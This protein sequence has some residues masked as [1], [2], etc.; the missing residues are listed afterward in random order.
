MARHLLWAALSFDRS[1][2]I[3]PTGDVTFA[4]RIDHI[5]HPIP[6]KAPK[7]FSH[8]ILDILEVGLVIQ[9]TTSFNEHLLM[10]DNVI[11]IFKID[12]AVL[13]GLGAYKNN[14]VAA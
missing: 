14:K 12:I 9:P 11:K 8:N 1:I 5:F 2:P 10:T 3:I 6:L 4:D 7:S 13:F